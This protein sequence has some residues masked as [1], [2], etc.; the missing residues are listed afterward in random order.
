MKVTR[1][2]VVCGKDKT[3]G[4]GKF[5]K[6]KNLLKKLNLEAVKKVLKRWKVHPPSVTAMLDKYVCSRCSGDLLKKYP[7]KTRKEGS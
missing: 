2:C 5:V 7:R 3:A 1:K 4:V 6:L